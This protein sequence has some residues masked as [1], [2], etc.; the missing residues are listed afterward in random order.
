MRARISLILPAVPAV[1]L[2]GLTLE[3]GPP[4]LIHVHTMAKGGSHGAQQWS[5]AA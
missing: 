2:E 4:L 3:Y 5:Y 1:A